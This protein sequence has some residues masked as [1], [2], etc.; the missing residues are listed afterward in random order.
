MG[1]VTKEHLS[2]VAEQKKLVSAT[3]VALTY[4]TAVPLCG[5]KGGVR[6][7]LSVKPF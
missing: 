4:L 6:D 7:A 5:A 3:K 1:Q 2:A